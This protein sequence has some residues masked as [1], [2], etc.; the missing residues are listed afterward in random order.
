MSQPGPMPQPPYDPYGGSG[1]PSYGTPPSPQPGYGPPGYG[2]PEYAAPEYPAPGYGPPGYTAPSSYGYAPQPYVPRRTS[3]LAIA[4]LVCSL[5]GLLTCVS[6]V[7]GIILGHIALSQIKQT[8]E[9][10]AGMAKAGLIIGY[11]IAAGLL[12]WVVILVIAGI[13]SSA[14]Q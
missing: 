12:V 9:E 13:A 1:A 14:Q 2:P 10:G 3:G 5:A 7:V 6:A 4:S 11:V 8:G